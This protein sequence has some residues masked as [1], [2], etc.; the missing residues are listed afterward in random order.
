M[1]M[2]Q[3]ILDRLNDNSLYNTIGVR[4]EE[5]GSGTARSR[6]EPDSKF[7][8]PFKGQP[9]GGILFTQ[10]DITMA[11]A[12]FSQLDWG[13]NCATIN[14]DIQYTAP[15]KGNHFI[16]S[17]R[18]THMTGHLTFVRAEIQDAEGQLLAMG[19]GTFRI[20]GTDVMK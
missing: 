20:I 13:H 14:L 19:Q 17:A 15:A 8:W 10:M 6:L 1:E 7:Y 4:V 3:E 12:V 16:C 9:H 18:T 5:A 2:T 11:W